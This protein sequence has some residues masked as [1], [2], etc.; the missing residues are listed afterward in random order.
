MIITD[1]FLIGAVIGPKAVAN[2]TIP[3]E[4]AARTLTIPQALSRALFPQISGTTSSLSIR[5]LGYQTSFALASIITPLTVA[6]IFL[7]RPFLELWIGNFASESILVGQIIL[8]AFWV[9]ALCFIPLT[10]IVG[11]GRPKSVAVTHCIELV[12]YLGVLYILTTNFGIEGAAIAFLLRCV[13]DYFILGHI[14]GL[15]RSLILPQM[16]FAALIVSAFCSSLY[17]NSTLKNGILSLTIFFVLMILII[18]MFKGRELKLV[19][20]KIIRR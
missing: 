11:S 5:K 4:I 3:F 16:V 15:L 18:F 8:I 2:Y 20:K 17:F 10:V 1:R 12:P 14:S 9:N 13:V 6:G 7:M 19:L